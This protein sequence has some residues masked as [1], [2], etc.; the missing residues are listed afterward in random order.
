MSYDHRHHFA[1]E[2]SSRFQFQHA[3]LSKAK[4]ETTITRSMLVA[5]TIVSWELY[6][7][8]SETTNRKCKPEESESCAKEQSYEENK[9]RR[10]INEFCTA[11]HS[12]HSVCFFPL[13]IFCLCVSWMRHIYMHVNGNIHYIEFNWHYLLNHIAF[14]S[15]DTRRDCSYQ[16]TLRKW[17]GANKELQRPFNIGHWAAI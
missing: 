10:Q 4:C 11:S 16:G 3:I 6:I 17:I 8:V 2:T 7:G 15:Q 5:K 12:T 9:I 14:K 1:F 13:F